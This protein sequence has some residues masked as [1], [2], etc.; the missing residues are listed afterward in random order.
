M[1]Q[2]PIF[3]K[4]K[5]MYIE[6]TRGGFMATLGPIYGKGSTQGKAKEKVL[7]ASEEALRHAEKHFRPEVFMVRDIIGIV[8]ADFP[9]GFSYELVRTKE[10]LDNKKSCCLSGMK[11][12]EEAER[13]CRIHIAQNLMAMAEG[14]S[15]V[16]A[17]VNEA[18]KA[19]HMLYYKWQCL[20]H[21]ARQAGKTDEE[22]RA[23]ISGLMY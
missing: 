21:A 20:Y 22:A 10:N 3:S 14:I 4:G 16:E 17:I 9:T 11:T 23:A 12:K 6:K 19:D 2:K 13:R 15:G 8:Y 1:A 5:T 18:D 7:S